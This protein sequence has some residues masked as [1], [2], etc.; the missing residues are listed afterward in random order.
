MHDF[1]D[2]LGIEERWNSSSSPRIWNLLWRVEFLLAD[3]A[4]ACWWCGTQISVWD[5]FL[6]GATINDIEAKSWKLLAFEPYSAGFEAVRKAQKILDKQL[7]HNAILK[8]DQFQL[9]RG[10]MTSSIPSML[11]ST[12]PNGETWW[13]TP[14]SPYTRGQLRTHLSQLPDPLRTAFQ[15]SDS[16][17][18]R[19]HKETFG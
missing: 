16:H 4:K 1:L 10:G 13:K 2:Q 6:S 12:S 7:E 3:H 14:Q 15:H 5:W 9:K 8:E 17:N 18:Q 11:W 19:N